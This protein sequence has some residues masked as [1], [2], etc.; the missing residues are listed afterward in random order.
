MRYLYLVTF[1][2]FHSSIIIEPIMVGPPMQKLG[3]G[4]VAPLDWSAYKGARLDFSDKTYTKRH[5]REQP[6]SVGDFV[7]VTL[8]V[9]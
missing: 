5:R 7:M 8:S 6:E 2:R 4:P 9:C 3:A 1:A